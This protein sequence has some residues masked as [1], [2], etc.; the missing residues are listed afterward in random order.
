[1]KHREE[2]EKFL[3][4]KTVCVVGPSTSML[5]IEGS[6]FNTKE[7]QVAKINSYDVIVRLNKA[8]PIS[9]ELSSF[10]GSR[11]DVLYNCMTPVENKTLYNIPYLSK[12]IKWMV[13]SMPAKPPA[14]FDIN[15]FAQINNNTINFTVPR[16]EYWD[17][18]E[19]EL[20][21]RPNTG[22]WTILDLLSCEIKELYITGIT[23]FRGGYIREYKDFNEEQ[24]LAY[25]EQDGHHKQPPQIKHM[26]KVLLSD[27]RVETDIFLQQIL[28][29]S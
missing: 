7:E 27:K 12:E 3:A 14:L 1:M 18:I 26:K 9:E 24:A 4:D 5:D 19:S 20:Q 21:T 25:L 2:Y 8:L 13:S 15:R 10:I 16:T 28:N 22:V 29:N 23:F 17:L 11:T 6:S